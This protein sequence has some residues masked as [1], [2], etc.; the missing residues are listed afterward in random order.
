MVKMSSTNPVQLL[1]WLHGKQQQLPR[2]R[3]PVYHDALVL[4]G[5]GRVVRGAAPP[6]H[7]VHH[8]VVLSTIPLL[9]TL[10]VLEG[11]GGRVGGHLTFR[12]CHS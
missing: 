11:G 12:I 1:Q 10:I 3:D 2:I 9:L 8:R 5:A 4:E 6:H 7:R